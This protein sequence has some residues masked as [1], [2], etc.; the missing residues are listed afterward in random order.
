MGRIVRMR[1]AELRQKVASQIVIRDQQ[2]DR[3]F[4]GE[5]F[6]IADQ[7]RLV[8]VSAGEGGFHPPGATSS[9]NLEDIREP[10][11]AA[12]ELRR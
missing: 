7:M 8:V 3:R 6:E 4:A 1:H 10:L 12:E 5:V 9:H 2:S 11:Y